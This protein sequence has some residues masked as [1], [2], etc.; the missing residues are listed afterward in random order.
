MQINLNPIGYV[1]NDIEK[2]KDESWGKDISKI[3][4]EKQYTGGLAGLNDFS[5][6]IIIYYLDIKPYYPV[7]DC[8]MESIVP[9]W[10]NRLMENYF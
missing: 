8:K 4:L 3:E 2:K 1:S 7:Y 6:A 5:Y 9:A 10:V